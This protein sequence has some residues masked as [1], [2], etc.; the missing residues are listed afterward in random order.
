MAIDHVFSVKSFSTFLFPLEF[1]VQKRPLKFSWMFLQ[2]CKTLPTRKLV[3][4]S[5]FVYRGVR[6]TECLKGKFHLHSRFYLKFFCAKVF[7][8]EKLLLPQE[9]FLEKVLPSEFTVHR[10]ILPCH[11]CAGDPISPVLSH[12]FT[13]HGTFK[14]VSTDIM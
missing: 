7:P 3:E 1:F 2:R 10:D 11:C 14:S 13:C 9:K 12:M 5:W 8:W 6:K 4:V